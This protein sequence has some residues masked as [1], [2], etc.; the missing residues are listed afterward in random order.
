MADAPDTSPKAGEKRSATVRD[1][2]KKPPKLR[3]FD[4][5]TRVPKR[6][7]ESGSS[8]A[9]ADVLQK[10][11]TFG[12]TQTRDSAQERMSVN[13]MF[14]TS[15]EL[16]QA[17]GS[18][19]SMKD[20][21]SGHQGDTDKNIV[22]KL[23]QDFVAVKM[24]GVDQAYEGDGEKDTVSSSMEE[25]NRLLDAEITSIQSRSVVSQLYDDNSD[26][27][28]DARVEHESSKDQD[29]G[30]YISNTTGD[31]SGSGSV[32]Q[33]GTFSSHSSL[34]TTSLS[35]AG[36][37][38]AKDGEATRSV[39][40]SGDAGNSSDLS[41]MF[42]DVGTVAAGAPLP[43]KKPLL[44]I[45][46][47][48]LSIGQESLARIMGNWKNGK[49]L[50]E[51]EVASTDSEAEKKS[52]AED[53]EESDNDISGTGSISDAEDKAEGKESKSKKKKKHK[54][55]H[56]KKKKHKS[57][58]DREGKD[59]EGKDREGKD[60]D[61]QSVERKPSKE[62]EQDGKKES[63]SKDKKKHRHRSRSNSKS[64]QRD[65][66]AESDTAP[67]SQSQPCPPSDSNT[68][69]K[70]DEDVDP[71]DARNY[72]ADGNLKTPPRAH[73]KDKDR[74]RDRSK[75]RSQ[76][77]SKERSRH[78]SKERSRRRSRDPSQDRDRRRSRSR[79]K[80]K[81][82]RDRGK[83]RG[84]GTGSDLRVRIDKN[85]LRKIAM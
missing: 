71:W 36:S 85:K 48:G 45:K 37:Q 3:R 35:E 53:S 38:A 73:S 14:R 16:Q 82:D 21:D 76:E 31:D 25:I 62:R 83:D 72:T 28:N 79:H 49:I 67:E 6:N 46:K 70:P 17:E 30:A 13:A 12:E 9:S 68:E 29:S 22:D 19:T 15:F 54:H 57:H 40:K 43:A 18:G 27:G 81:K 47:L 66:K 41:G 33:S 51:G 10:N 59:K 42:E 74:S 44:G 23:F 26:D 60:K 78:K 2:A 64:S 8:K 63:K 61:G 84:D 4:M 39:T 69:K 77:R 75:E 5:K 80:D 7:T 58:K 52:K 24:K 32:E 34:L 20:S 55:K 56:K 65:K 50:E 1:E 11:D